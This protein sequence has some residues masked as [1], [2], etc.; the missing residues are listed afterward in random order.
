MYGTK[1]TKGGRSSNS[2]AR[3]TARRV[4]RRALMARY[5]LGIVGALFVLTIVPTAAAQVAKSGRA[6]ASTPSD[7]VAEYKI[8]PLDKLSIAVYRIEELTLESVQVDASGRLSLPLVGT[9]EV[10]GRTAPQVAE[11]IASKLKGS[12]LQD[13]QVTVWVVEATSQKVTVDGAVMQPGVYL[14]SGKTTL[15]QAVAMAKGPDN[16]LANLE[17]VVVFREVDGQRSVAVFNLKR[18]RRGLDPDPII[19]GNDVVVVDGSQLKQVWREVIGTLPGLAIF[20]P[21]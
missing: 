13:P 15:M 1:L 21:Y 4:I 2:N 17:R 8:G 19:L 18:I 11:E 9:I 20:R 7:A 16:K 14:L 10:N 5:L 3:R 12:Y 6:A